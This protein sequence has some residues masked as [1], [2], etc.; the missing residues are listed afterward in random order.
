M[1]KR[2]T[3]GVFIGN[4]NSP[5]TR[6]LIKGIYNAAESKD[7]DVLFYLSY[8]M[9]FYENIFKGE[10]S[11]VSHDYQSNVVYDYALLSDVDALIINYGSL[12]IYMEDIGMDKFLSKYDGIPYVILEDRDQVGKGASIISDNYSGMGKIVEHLVRDHGYR[13]FAYLSGPM[14]N[15]D[16]RERRQAFDDVL[17]KYGIAVNPD[18]V[19]EGDFTQNVY[20]QVERLLDRNPN[21]EALVCANDIMAETA[22]KV[23]AKRGLFVGKDIAVTGYD[24]YE[25]AESMSPPL[26]TVLQN[27]FDMA[28][29]A[30]EQALNM[31]R[32]KLG[33]ELRAPAAPR[34]RASCGCK[35]ASEYAI[36]YNA[37]EITSEEAYI[38]K[39]VKVIVSKSIL[40]NADSKVREQI[41][42][43]IRE[44]VI[45]YI[46]IYNAGTLDGYDKKKII[47]QVSELVAGKYGAYVLPMALSDSMVALIEYRMHKE[48]DIERISIL[49]DVLNTI[50][51]AIQSADSKA[52]SEKAERYQQDSCYIP[53]ISREMMDSIS[54]PKEFYKAPM[55]I[56]EALRCRASYLFVYD[57]P[58]RHRAKHKW[59]INKKMYL[60]SYHEGQDIVS[61]DP[62]K[63]PVVKKDGSSFLKCINRDDRVSL[64]AYALFQ[65]EMQYGM[66][67]CEVEPEDQILIYLAG[68]QISQAIGYLQS[69]D[70]QMQMRSKLE[71]LVDDVKEKNK[72]LGFISEYDQLTGCLN[73]RGFV[74]QVMEISRENEGSSAFFILGDLDHLKEVNDTFGHTEG[75]FAISSCAEILRKGLG[76]NALV[77]RIGGDEFAVFYLNKNGE[78]A[79]ELT[80]RI[81]AYNKQFNDQTG[82]PYY[83]EVSV[84]MCELEC[85]PGRDIGEYMKRADVLLYD[86]KKSRRASIKR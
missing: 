10:K 86:A 83:V 78:K 55:K 7:V 69:Y 3:I 32:G 27:E 64:T 67:L 39:V 38:N 63:R 19:E 40:A 14:F 75:D 76:D 4:A 17:S 2:F 85:D 61:F 36:N 59:D 51:R 46:N 41:T 62:D 26:T 18:M 1:D 56:L 15:Y 9:D 44:L 79:E 28:Y 53:L 11:E 52:E 74:E 8:H 73:R 65:G 47:T 70:K 22:Y 29:V 21:L 49:S 33:M 31:C 50:Q 66:L 84:G 30:V 24:D 35:I 23:I 58:V 68:M 45:E 13:N 42:A 60:A 20:E 5:H 34:I 71:A 43:K 48:S 72:I 6:D 80:A 12:C 54:D 16:A 57:K 25:Q 77:A 81:K 82:K 37:E